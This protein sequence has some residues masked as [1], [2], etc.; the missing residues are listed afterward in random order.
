MYS[1]LN[2]VWKFYNISITHIF[3]EINFRDTKSTKSTILSRL[4]A[5]NFDLYAF[6]HFQ[7]AEIDQIN[8]IQIPQ[9]WKNGIGSFKT[10]EFSKI[11]FS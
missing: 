3:R 4:E 5:L 8:K 6:L 10:S 9:K 7:K 2:T 1:F 11:D